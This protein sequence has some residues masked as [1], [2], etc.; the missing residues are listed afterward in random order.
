MSWMVGGA[1]RRRMV[2]TNERDAHDAWFRAKVQEAL[3]DTRPNIP[4]EVVQA[5]VA[6]RRAAM[7]RRIA[8]AQD[9]PDEGKS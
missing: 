4:Q 6:A 1:G 8:A 9:D 5:D 7:R 3:D 2:M